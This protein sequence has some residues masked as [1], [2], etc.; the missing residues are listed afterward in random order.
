MDIVLA[1]LAPPA[2]CKQGVIASAWHAAVTMALLLM[3]IAWCSTIAYFRRM[4]MACHLASIITSGFN[5]IVG[6]LHDF[7]KAVVVATVTA[8]A[9]FPAMGFSNFGACR[10]GREHDKHRRHGPS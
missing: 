9:F 2:G 7:T 5:F 4:T 3:R 1:W 6:Y 8:A 10:R